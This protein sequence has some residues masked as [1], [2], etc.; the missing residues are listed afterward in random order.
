MSAGMLFR[1]AVKDETPLQIPGT[2]NANHALLARQAGYRAIYLS[3]GGVAAGSLGLPDLGDDLGERRADRAALR[4]RD[5]QGV[6]RAGADQQHAVDVAVLEQP[7]RGR[8]GGGHPGVQR[9]AVQPVEPEFPGAVPSAT[10]GCGA[11]AGVATFASGPV[12]SRLP[13]SDWSDSGSMA[14]AVRRSRLSGSSRSIRD[15]SVAYRTKAPSVCGNRAA[16]PR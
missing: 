9:I 2:I 16:E 5:Q 8:L 11:V 12:A 13:S 7:E 10:L 1:Q 3:G 15:G 14:A 6:L 4:A